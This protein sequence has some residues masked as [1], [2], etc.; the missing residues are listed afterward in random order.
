MSQ[1]LGRGLGSLIPKKTLNLDPADTS[2]ESTPVTI[3]DEER[4]WPVAPNFI[5]ANPY[6]PRTSFANQALQELVDSIRQHGILQPLV[7]TRQGNR[8]QLIAGERRLRAAIEL[9]LDTVPVLIRQADEQKKLELALIE[10]L[11]RQDLNPIESAIAYRRLIDEFNLTQ[12]EAALKVGKARSS[13]TNSLRLLSLPES[14]QKSL[15]SGHLS[16]AHAKY[17]LGIEDPDQQLNIFKKIL[18]HSLSVS[19]TDQLIKK[20]GG[21]KEA[22]LKYHGGDREQEEKL[23]AHFGTKVVIK[24]QGRGGRLIIEFYSEEELLAIIQKIRQSSTFH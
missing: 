1:A 11:Q 6:Q 14:I 10:N 22:R 13:L 17:L 8:F 15:A 21:T 16:E 7:V 4:I 23:Q 5:D 20:L 3:S 24:R 9:G 19:E 12:E 18:R 2:L